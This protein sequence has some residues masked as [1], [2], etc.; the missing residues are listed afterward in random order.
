MGS[1]APD[2]EYFLLMAPRGKFGHTPAGM[3]LFSL[4]AAL[5]ALWMFH[6]WVKP[7]IVMILPRPLRER[8]TRSLGPF[9]FA[10]G[11]RFL[12]IA[13]SAFAGIAT[14]IAW[15]SFTHPASPLVQHWAVLRSM[16]TVP[17]LGTHELCRILQ[18]F[19]TVI[20]LGALGV[21]FVLWYRRTERVA[22]DEPPGKYRRRVALWI[23][24]PLGAAAGA[25]ARVWI[26]NGGHW[27][28]FGYSLMVFAV[29]WI[30]L[31][32][33]EMVAVG[34]FADS[35]GELNQHLRDVNAVLT[36]PFDTDK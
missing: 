27:R 17:L 15:D 21:W 25:A 16:H 1:V 18:L 34:Y 3:F 28:Y 23:G 30:A 9:S 26:G 6:R 36:A 13:A 24:L 22:M 5:A 35:Y 32:W 2:F 31:L 20:G 7:V 8:F 33:W 10:P 12:L 4:P 14:H 11:K 29:A 19:S